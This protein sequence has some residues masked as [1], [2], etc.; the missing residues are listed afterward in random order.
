MTR[1][2]VEADIRS[3]LHDL[4]RPME[5]WDESG[6]FLG[7]FIP[8]LDHS[9]YNLQPQISRQEAERRRQSQEKTYTTS[10][11]LAYLENL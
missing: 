9:Q 10:E 2:T 3:K 8:A 4:A 7:R 6:N 1:I 11:V 5:F